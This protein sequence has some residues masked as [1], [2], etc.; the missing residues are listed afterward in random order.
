MNSHRS[1]N[2]NPPLPLTVAFTTPENYAARLSLLLRRR[3][4]TPLWCPTV[5]VEPTAATNAALRIHISRLHDFSAVA[6]TSRAG[7]SAFDSAVSA[8]QSPPLSSSGEDFI[9]SALGKDAEL[10]DPDFVSKICPNSDR[11]KL[12]VPPNPTPRGL[13]ESLG[14]GLGRKVF[15]PV[16]LVL[17]LEEPP[18]VPHF[19]YDL[20]QMGWAPVRVN[21]YVTRWAG[22]NCTKG[23]WDMD[24][25]DA[26]I[27]TSTTEVEG[28]LKGL[29]ELGLGWEDVR[30]R[31][32]GLV[33]AAHGPVTASGAERLGV[34]VDV[35]SSRFSSFDGVV[36]ALDHTFRECSM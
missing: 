26:I 18:V 3:S 20:G 25:A 15:C 11:V 30:K 10:L 21:A 1:P 7:I 31:W 22:P 2:P 13:A 14:P 36:E 8:A 5:V 6:F 28:L 16:P 29:R 17:G 12:V 9:L 23:L 4:W 35:V 34:G 33:V 19:L 32:P 27:F 24:H